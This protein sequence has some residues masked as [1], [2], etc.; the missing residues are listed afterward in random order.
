MKLIIL[1]RNH[2]RSIKHSNSDGDEITVGTHYK[3]KH[4]AD[5]FSDSDTAQASMKIPI[6]GCLGSKQ[7]QTKI[8]TNTESDSVYIS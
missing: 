3:Y 7:Y 5:V 4:Q 2:Q 6:L 8:H 1:S